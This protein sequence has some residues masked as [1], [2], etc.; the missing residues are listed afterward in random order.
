MSG[1]AG[2]TIFSKGAGR[3]QLGKKFFSL[4]D[5]KMLSLSLIWHK[6]LRLEVRV[7]ECGGLL[8]ILIFA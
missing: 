7:G 3:T 4:G 5:I 2:I 6:T 8:G 1:E